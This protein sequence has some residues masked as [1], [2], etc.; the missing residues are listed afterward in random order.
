MKGKTVREAL[1]YV[2]SHPVQEGPPIEAPVWEL[3]GR[4]LFKIAN[5]PDAKKRGSMARATKAQRIIADRLVGTRRP[6]TSPAVK[7]EQQ[8]EFRDLTAGLT[9]PG[10]GDDD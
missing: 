7:R 2:A 3:V 5:S 1:Q 6:G 4:A 9:G 8:I 10:E